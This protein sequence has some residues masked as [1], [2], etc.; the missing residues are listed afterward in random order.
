MKNAGV[1]TTVVVCGL[2]EIYIEL[3]SKQILDENKM[4]TL[5]FGPTIYTV[6]K[7]LQLLVM[8][9]YVFVCQ[10]ILISTFSGFRCKIG[11]GYVE[12]STQQSSTDR[13]QPHLQ[14]QDISLEPSS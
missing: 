3:K 1:I 7:V 10:L 14:I 4:L 5:V 2:T 8:L 13:N 12:I 6:L 9:T 11:L